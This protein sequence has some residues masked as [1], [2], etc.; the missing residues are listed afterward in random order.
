MKIMGN[1]SA[2][3]HL[4]QIY[5]GQDYYEITGATTVAG[6]M[7]FYLQDN[8]PSQIDTLISDIAEFTA[9]YTNTLDDE[10]NTRWGDDF[11]PELWGTTPQGFLHDVQNL[12]LQHKG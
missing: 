2:L 8:S 12:A 1:F 3:E 9:A 10:L 4:I 7:A 11:S 5:F 6:V